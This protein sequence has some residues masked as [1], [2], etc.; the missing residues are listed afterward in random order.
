MRIW[1]IGDMEYSV[2]A[3]FLNEV[4]QEQLVELEESSPVR[5]FLRKDIFVTH[6]EFQHIKKDTD[7][8]WEYFMLQEYPLF[9]ERCRE[10]QGQPRD[11]G[12]RRM[13]QVSLYP[14][15]DSWI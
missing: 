11:R 9:H 1:D 2:V 4:P 14:D 6:A 3:P 12:W 5:S 7:W 15:A 10:R 8:L 13:F